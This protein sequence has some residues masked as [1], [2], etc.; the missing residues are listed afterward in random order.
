[1]AEMYTIAETCQAFVDCLTKEHM[2]G[3]NVD[4]ETARATLISSTIIYGKRPDYLEHGALDDSRG[5]RYLKIMG[6]RVVELAKTMK[7]AAEANAVP[8]TAYN[9]ATGSKM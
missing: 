7:Y 2:A 5:M 6:Q 8:P 1:M 3:M 9:I 4:V